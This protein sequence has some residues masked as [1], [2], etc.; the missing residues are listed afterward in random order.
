MAIPRATTSLDAASPSDGATPWDTATVLA[1]LGPF[2]AKVKTQRMSVEVVAVATHVPTPLPGQT[3]LLARPAGAAA[4]VVAVY[5]DASTAT[6]K[7]STDSALFEF[8]AQSG[9]LRIHAQSIQLH[10]VDSI[11]LHCADATFSLSSRGELIS[12]AQ[13]ITQAAIGA[14]RIEGAS[15]DIN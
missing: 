15:V 13:T 3:V 8:D 7:G 2:S 1:T 6:P 10:G 14:H 11:E 12:T 9:V 5:G 4:L